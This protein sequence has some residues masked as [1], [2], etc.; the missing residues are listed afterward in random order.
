M[1]NKSRKTFQTFGYGSFKSYVHLSKVGRHSLNVG[2]PLQKSILCRTQRRTIWQPWTMFAPSVIK[3]WRV[4]RLL[5]A[6]TFSMPW[7]CT[8]KHF[9]FVPKFRCIWRRLY[10]ECEGHNM[11]H[12]GE[13]CNWV[14]LY[15]R[16][17]SLTL[18][19]T[20][21]NFINQDRSTQLILVS[22]GARLYTSLN[23]SWGLIWEY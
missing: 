10:I 1:F 18:S 5:V 7:V 9:L 20:V 17:S 22:T 23:R 19:G 11:N 14:W 21:S 12:G 16:L 8:Y 4:Q 6:V 15:C 3:K 13:K 2:L